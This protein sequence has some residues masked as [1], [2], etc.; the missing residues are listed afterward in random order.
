MSRIERRQ[1]ARI[2]RS[3]LDEVRAIRTLLQDSYKDAGDGR[4]LVREL[5]QNADDAEAARLVFSVLDRGFPDATNTLLRGP[6]LLVAND[7]PFRER[8]WKAIH[9]ALGGSKAEEFGKVGRFGVG[10]KSAFHICEAVVYLGAE[11][12]LLRPGVLN[13]WAGTGE[14]GDADP[15]HPD[16]DSVDDADVHRLHAAAKSLLHAFRNGLLLWIPLRQRT[17]L[18]RA[19]GQEYG[20]TEICQSPVAIREWFQRPDGLSL[21]L[22]QCGH[23][24]SIKAIRTPAEGEPPQSLV[25]LERPGFT[26]EGWVGRPTDDRLAIH[27]SFEGV[28]RS[29]ERTWDVHG[30]DVLGGEALRQLRARPDWPH[31]QEWVRGVVRTIPR[32]ALG[33]AAVTVLRTDSRRADR[34]RAHVR[35]AVF[36]PLDDDPDPRPGNLVECAD[37]AGGPYDWEIVLHGYFW[38]SHD[39]RSIPGVTTDEAGAGVGAIRAEWNRAVR[40]EVLLPLLPSLLADVV[41]RVDEPVA[42]ALLSALAASSLV[43]DNLDS[44][45]RQTVLLPVLT[46][47]GIRFEARPRESGNLSVPEW[48]GAPQAVRT[49]FIARILETDAELTFTHAG[50]P[51]IGGGAAAWPVG[52]LNR[53]LE[54]VTAGALDSAGSVL[55]AES[56]VQ[57]AIGRQ[58]TLDDGRAAAVAD[59]LGRSIGDR[60]LAPTTGQDDGREELRNAWRRLFRV[61]PH[62][63]LVE[64]PIESQQALLEL[65]SAGF[66]GRGLLPVPLGRSDAEI[67][68]R[69][70]QQRLDRA[71]LELGA[72]LGNGADG[73]KTR[74]RSRLLLAERLL[75]ARD[76][77]AL[78]D[79]LARLPLLRAHRLPDGED[80]P[81]SLERLRDRTGSYR[82]FSKPGSEPAPEADAPTDFRKAVHDL[83]SALGGHVWLVEHDVARFSGAPTPQVEDLAAAVLAADEIRSEPSARI[84]LVRRL[85]NSTD[86]ADVQ[87]ALRVMLGG[88]LAANGTDPLYFARSRDSE[89]EANERSLTILLRLLGQPCRAVYEQLAEALPQTLCDDLDVRSVDT[90][91][92]HHLLSECLAREV[93]WDGL[94]RAEVLHLLQQLNGPTPEVRRYWRAMPLHRRIDG[95]RGPI[96]GGT[97]KSHGSAEI[98]PELATE[99]TL[100]DPDPEVVHLYG[101]VPKLDEDGILQLMLAS[102]RPHQFVHRILRAIRPDRGGRLILPRDPKT[103]ELLGRAEWLPDGRGAGIGPER[104]LPVPPELRSSVAALAA[105]GILGEYRLSSDVEADLWETAEPVVREILQLA[106]AVAQVKRIANAVD[107]DRIGGLERGAYLVLTDPDHV[108]AELIGNVLQTPVVGSLPGWSLLHGAARLLGAPVELTDLPNAS[109]DALLALARS[110]CAPLPA[111]RQVELL[112]AIAAGRPS[113]DSAGGRAFRALLDH[114]AADKAF[115]ADV[116][117]H[118]ALPTQDGQWHPAA[119]IARST[120]GLARRH[121]LVT[122]LRRSLHLD[123]EAPVAQRPGTR[124]K[125][126][127]GGTVDNADILGQYFDS[128]RG[129]VPSGA[130]GAFLS[131]LGNGHQEGILR[132]AGEW[133]GEDVSVEG[134]RGSLTTTGGYDP[135]ATVKVF[136]EI[137]VA[138]AARLAALNILGDHVE[139]EAGTD[140]STIFATDPARERSV[141]GDYWVVVLRDVEPQHRTAHEL[142]D[143]L[144]QTV[145]WWAVRI[146]ALDPTVVQEWWSRWGRGSQAQIGPVRASILAHLPLTLHQLGVHGDEEL[147]RALRESQRA[148]RRR[149]QALPEQQQVA[150]EHERKV[151]QQ[152]AELI[153]A[154]DHRRF[155]WQRVQEQMLR[156]GYRRDSVLLEL[157]QNA[158]DALAQA[159]EIAVGEIPTAARRLLVR[160]HRD[161]GV[162]CVD[163]LHY[164][165]P[166]NDTGGSRF[167][168][169]RDRQWDQDLYFMML[170]NM[171]S[172]PGEV[173]G[174]SSASSTTGRFGLGFK[175]IHLVSAAPTVVSGFLAFSIVG[176][177]LPEEEPLPEDAELTPVGGHRATRIRLPLRRDIDAD[178]PISDLF[179]RFGYARALIPVF[180][181]QIR[182]VVVDGGSNPGVSEFEPL[183]VGAAAGWEVGSHPTELPDHSQW[184][185]LRFRPGDAGVG[186]GTAALAIGLRNRLPAPFPRDM[187]FL[188]N[189]TP[190]SESWGCGYAINGPFKLDPG[191]THVSLDD[192]ATVKLVDSLGEELGAGLIALHDAVLDESGPAGPFPFVF[193]RT[194]FVSALWEVLSTGVAGDDGLRQDLI[195]RLHGSG[196]GLSVWM[197][198]RSVVPTGMPEPFLQRLPPLGKVTHIEISAGGLED[199]E[200]CRAAAA[201]DELMGVIEERCVITQRVAERLRPFLR[202]AMSSLR[203]TDLFAALATRWA[204]LLTPER[205][206]AL[207]ALTDDSLWSSISARLDGTPW[208]AQLTA[209]SASG[210]YAPLRQ[211]LLPP[212]APAG[213]DPDVEEELRR[214]AFAPDASVLAAGYIRGPEDVAVFRRLRGP[215][216]VDAATLAGWYTD[217]PDS[218]WGAALQYLL[219]GTRNSL[220]LER[221]VPEQ[222][223]PEWLA[224]YDAVLEMLNTVTDDAWRRESLLAALFPEHYEHLTE[225]APILPDDVKRDFFSRLEEWWDDPETRREVTASYETRVWPDWLQ[226]QGLAEGLKEGSPDHWLALLVLG[227]CQ[228]LGLTLPSQHRVFIENARREGWWEVFKDPERTSEWMEVLRAWQ[229]RSTDDLSYA[230]W[231]SL[232]PSIYQLSRFRD[233]YQRL[234]VSAGRRPE[235]LYQVNTLLAPRVD[236]ALT[237]AGQKFDAPPA[238]LDMGVHWILR[239]LVRL[240][241]M[242]LH[243]NHVLPD[244]WVPAEQVITFL[245][246][247]G[248]TPPDFGARNAQ[249]ARAVSEFLAAELG[250]AYPHLH[251][252]FDIPLRHVAEN[253][254]LRTDLGL[255]D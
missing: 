162:P 130:V 184:G 215:Y 187:P 191:R 96:D 252:A 79:E 195:G 218:R 46:A 172:K 223:R 80:E 140:H 192:V 216:Q 129:R 219:H 181:R 23:L 66:I 29:D 60:A 87:A 201:I 71:L 16:W 122:E 6:A 255:E 119:E 210:E 222:A 116:L 103:R 53:F 194:G 159:S 72:K 152:L 37:L 157:A 67:R 63:W 41:A 221:I 68:P 34:A 83:A 128:W 58:P 69:P 183:A 178:G 149:E 117:P 177:L 26:K 124:P 125:R 132:L 207:R 36:L 89:R 45:T 233:V 153:K 81:W 150:F 86:T 167:P 204:Q 220:V 50:A 166:I 28:V 121:L 123:I 245:R 78:T 25:H 196:R 77:R 100:L 105:G 238:P 99:I 163:V 74:Q 165:R 186:T 115:F 31:D 15:I 44:I 47:E 35:W 179:N 5:V 12:D 209:R 217:L 176:G 65:A 247:L 160:V 110:L 249:K 211:L 102:R 90:G 200:F 19:E 22:A 97:V 236:Q 188:W 113:R 98:P 206:H 205:L 40:D 107:L 73:S 104:L 156:F 82:V 85:A 24:R 234:L 49:E 208:H 226:Q 170:L 246:P 84:A 229:D 70:D 136:V 30:V 230:R 131:L 199:P 1:N 243:G 139:M 62:E 39:R 164:G 241:V 161:G 173:P 168:E 158:D 21:L 9:R 54:C 109:R 154:D 76:G 32:K 147:Q 18:D 4:T 56:L 146:L 88:P 133:L 144:A 198:A 48:E 137:I 174:H 213:D 59:W 61:L 185:I 248:L 151:L 11:D 52:W 251:Y 250:T 244:C 93:G 33:H 127:F 202:T 214:T 64:A 55:W 126:Q 118:L 228:S 51:R 224:D 10:L 145:E 148:Q 8:D 101:D 227:A 197:E 239:E 111:Q 114:F 232:F 112:G 231:M 143:L 180:A 203:P 212:D 240:R 75:A 108:S 193:D 20:L 190:T 92:L 106:S 42:R 141:L 2:E 43:R 169:G 175:S 138:G 237:G 171:S 38:P 120:S 182:E 17:H 91:Q 14:S 254:N 7:G 253:G 27:R 134:V 13:P 189:V 57:H 155:L 3:A 225:E 142:L 235:D 242:P 94:D 135:C 95:G